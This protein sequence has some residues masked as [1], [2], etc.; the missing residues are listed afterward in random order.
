MDL[1]CKCEEAQ[2]VRA[3]VSGFC[4]KNLL[5]PLHGEMEESG[6]YRVHSATDDWAF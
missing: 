6:A 3:A 5:G 1:V 2:K 4:R